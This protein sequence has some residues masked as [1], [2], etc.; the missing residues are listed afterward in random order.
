QLQRQEPPG[1]LYLYQGRRAASANQRL[2]PPVIIRYSHLHLQTHHLH[3]S[4]TTIPP[5]STSFSRSFDFSLHTSHSR[6]QCVVQRHFLY[7]ASPPVPLR[8]P[9]RP[10]SSTRVAFD[11]AWFPARI[12]KPGCVASGLCHFLLISAS[13]RP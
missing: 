2:P 11:R 4:T 6:R 5:Y 10:A 12:S 3:S 1:C 8:Q 9:S 7:S 13:T